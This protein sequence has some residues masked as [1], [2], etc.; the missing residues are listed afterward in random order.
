MIFL[1]PP[2]ES[3]QPGGSLSSSKLSFPELRHAREEIH[4]ALVA[5]SKDPKTGAASLKLGP[6]QLGELEVN[7]SLSKPVVMPAIDRY[8]GVLYEALK[9]EGL[10]NKQRSRAKK[11]LFIQ[12]SLFG[13]ISALDKIPNYRLSAGSKL[14]GVSLR[15]TWALAHEGIWQK[16]RNQIVIDL[17][18]K[19]YAQ[20]AP[21][22]AWI[23]SYEVEVLSEDTS[24]SRKALNHFNKQAKG[25]FARSAL[26]IDPEPR[27]VSELIQIA[28]LANLRLEISGKTLL[29][30]TNS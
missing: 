17:R 27:N 18:S 16:F 11:N 28:K 10:D 21:I 30:I 8:T 12:S 4:K 26:L 6:K 1:L 15:N 24:G 2:S 9:L 20:L 19:I 23:E 29:L 22:P 5:V 3:K 25:T 14:P 7:L 13:L